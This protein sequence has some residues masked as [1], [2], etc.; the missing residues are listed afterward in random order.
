MSGAPSD[1]QIGAERP[2]AIR[3]LR[4]DLICMNTA[5]NK[6]GPHSIAEI[7][8]DTGDAGAMID[9]RTLHLEGLVTLVNSNPYIDFITLL[10]TGWNQLIRSMSWDVNGVPVE[11]V[12]DYST[13]DECN[14]IQEGSFQDP[15]LLTFRNP[16]EVAGGVAG[17]MHINFVKPPCVNAAGVPWRADKNKS[18]YSEELPPNC[19]YEVGQREFTYSCN[20]PYG[21]G[22]QTPNRL[23]GS[24]QLA[25]GEDANMIKRGINPFKTPYIT[26][27]IHGLSMGPAYYP[28]DMEKLQVDIEKNHQRRTDLNR[29]MQGMHNV[30]YIPCHHKLPDAYKTSDHNVYVASNMDGANGSTK[31]KLSAS[32]MGPSASGTTRHEYRFKLPLNMGLLGRYSQKYFPSSLIGAGRMSLRIEF[33]SVERAFTFSMDPCDRIPG[34]LR[35]WAPFRGMKNTVNVPSHVRDGEDYVPFV[36][37]RM[38]MYLQNADTSEKAKPFDNGEARDTQFTHPFVLGDAA[39]MGTFCVGSECL[40]LMEIEEQDAVT[41]IIG[42][43]NDTEPVDFS[44]VEIRGSVVAK[45][46]HYV[47]NFSPD[48]PDVGATNTDAFKAS[49]TQPYAGAAAHTLPATE[50]ATVQDA[51]SILIDDWEQDKVEPYGTL[52]KMLTGNFQALA[53]PL[54]QYYPYSSPM[55]SRSNIAGLN[56]TKV[57]ESDLCFGTYLKH[58]VPQTRRCT[59]N[60]LPLGLAST[61]YLNGSLTYE[62][63]NLQLSMKQVLL[64]D[65]T[66]DGLLSQAMGG[67]A[68]ME[69]TLFKSAVNQLPQV[70][71]QNILIPI[72][73]ASIRRITSVFRHPDQLYGSGAQGFQ[74]N[75]FINPFVN[76]QT[77]R[78]VPLPLGGF[79]QSPSY[80]SPFTCALNNGIKVQY[81]LGSDYIPRKEIDSTQELL[82]FCQEGDGIFHGEMQLGTFE[83]RGGHKEWLELASELVRTEATGGS[84]YSVNCI[85]DGFFAPHIPIT[86]LSDQTVTG[87]P[88]F[89]PN[90]TRGKYSWGLF[91]PLVGTFHLPLNLETFPGNGHKA[92]DGA[93]IVNNNLYLRMNKAKACTQAQLQMFSIAECNAKIVFERGG[94][95]TMIS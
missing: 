85:K 6:H 56:Y 23:T 34:T 12:T 69:T 32:E 22:G 61:E 54:A 88:F 93:T 82:T 70:E 46:G 59:Q 8:L 71:N 40:G 77:A 29:V 16:W 91:E 76:V 80:E 9:P 43:D 89:E 24:T 10:R 35:D 57:E 49:F 66:M 68:I 28:V 26:A 75:S 2:P 11:S 51:A 58:S 72:P 94:S 64:P 53:A 18:F 74:L 86:H 73:G 87:N 14:R 92:R 52:Q 79:D 81:Q 31:W 55:A 33:E 4:R 21:Q 20:H 84:Q 48:I 1:L 30:K 13:V 60:L 37:R 45:P 95:V 41:S 19:V 42:V 83:Q 39:C 27:A 15:F 63:T 17:A 5:T 36:G 67:N 78:N 62:V 47:L 3:G 7:A 65:V 25:A 90:D 44:N 38:R 50:A